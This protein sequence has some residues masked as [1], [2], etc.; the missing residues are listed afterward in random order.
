MKTKTEIKAKIKQLYNCKK[1]IQ[2]MPPQARAPYLM[3]MENEIMALKW[4]IGYKVSTD[5]WFCSSCLIRHKGEKCPKC[6]GV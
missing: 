4:A 5:Y 6:D 1:L 2:Y 3:S